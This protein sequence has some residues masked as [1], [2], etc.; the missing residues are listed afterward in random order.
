MEE[1]TKKEEKEKEKQEEKPLDRMTAK[2]LREIAREIQGV[3]G[4]HAMKKEEL[5]AVVKEHRGIK[6]EGPVRKKK[7]KTARPAPDVKGL[8]KRITQLR[9]ER[10][11]ASEERDRRKVSIIRRRISRLKKQTRKVAQA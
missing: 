10:E 8:K 11:V 6:E 5:L 1:E 9:R 2:E 3:A 4:V 7:K